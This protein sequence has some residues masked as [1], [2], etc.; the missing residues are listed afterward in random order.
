MT[1]STGWQFAGWSP[2]DDKSGTIEATVQESQMYTATYRGQG[3]LTYGGNAQ[4]GGEV[5]D[6]PDEQTVWEGTTVEL[7]GQTPT[8]T[9]VNLSLIHILHQFHVFRFE[10]SSEEPLCMEVLIYPYPEMAYLVTSFAEDDLDVYKR[11]PL[12]MEIE[13]GKPS[14]LKYILESKAKGFQHIIKV[15]YIVQPKALAAANVVNAPP[16][17]LRD[18]LL[19]YVCQEEPRLD[20][21]HPFQKILR[22]LMENDRFP[23]CRLLGGCLLYTSRCV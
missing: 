23:G 22:R 19:T 4:S 6:L 2:E 5:F 17:L 21:S 15:L 8:H 9:P 20:G 11:Q 10:A 12:A 7:S 14:G 1:A 3:T 18:P 13:S 16:E